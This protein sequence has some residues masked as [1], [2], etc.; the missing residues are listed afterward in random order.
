MA[1]ATDPVCGMTVD[2]GTAAARS[3][4]DGESY[5]FCSVHCRDQFDANP[6]RYARIR[7]AD[8]PEPHKDG[9]APFT[10]SGGITAPKFG[11][12]GSGGAEYEPIREDRDRS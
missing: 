5:F 1:K 2:T 9:D 10:Q 12:A 4:F 3:T 6:E 8:A 7:A 11:S